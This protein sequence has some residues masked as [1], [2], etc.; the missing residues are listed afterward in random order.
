MTSF[1]IRP[2]SLK[3]LHVLDEGAFLIVGQVSPESVAMVLNQV[4]RLAQLQQGWYQP[5]QLIVILAV[6]LERLHQ[7]RQQVGMAHQVVELV[8][9]RR[10]LSRI[11]EIDICEQLYG[12][13]CRDAYLDVAY[14][15]NRI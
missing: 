11:E 8:N 6:I 5:L 7:P 15:Q 2:S 4:G 14:L 3:G 10:R 9:H 1:C 12:G 13:A